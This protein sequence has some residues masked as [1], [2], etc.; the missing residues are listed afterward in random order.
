MTL[1]DEQTDQLTGRELDAA[2]A[3][4][5]LKWSVFECR[6]FTDL[7]DADD[8]TINF[9]SDANIALAI[10]EKIDRPK[11]SMCAVQEHPRQGWRCRFL[12]LPN[13]PKETDIIDGWGRTLAESICRAAL[14][15]ATRGKG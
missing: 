9:S 5:V 3:R 10:I 7:F 2:V 4:H 1:S 11:W 13:Q 15:V 14:K 6:R 8:K 12:D